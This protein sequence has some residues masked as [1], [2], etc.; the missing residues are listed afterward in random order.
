M[1]LRVTISATIALLALFLFRP[2][3]ITLAQTSAPP[4]ATRAPIVAPSA[5]PYRVYLPLIFSNGPVLAKKGVPLTYSAD[6]PVVATMGAWWQYS[7]SPTP[8][9]C[10]GIENVPMI[11]V[12]SEINATLTGNSQWILGFNEPDESWQPAYMDPATGAQLWRQIEQ[13]YP[14]S[15]GKKLMSPGT[16]SEDYTH[17]LLN[18]RNSYIAQYGTPPRLDGLAAHCLKWWASQAIN[19]CVP[20]YVDWANAWGASEVWVTEFAFATNPS[21]GAGASD[22]QAAQMEKQFIDWMVTQPKVTRYAW[23]ASRIPPGTEI[24]GC[25]YTP[26]VDYYN[27]SQ[28]TTFGTVYMPYR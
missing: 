13:K 20:K 5:G 9:N 8:A 11:S 28:P 10:P 15:S 27:P 23:F 7:W 25:F 14:P 26:L 22:S 16:G 3:T 24:P 4:P 21:C 2:N 6:C 18:F 12:P 17:W 1:H 19:D